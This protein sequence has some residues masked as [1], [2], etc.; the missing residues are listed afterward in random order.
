M[1]ELRARTERTP[2]AMGD[3]PGRLA[4]HS[5]WHSPLTM[6][7][8][9]SQWLSDDRLLAIMIAVDNDNMYANQWP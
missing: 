8:R 4:L 1:T 6:Q 9:D 2:L 3:K 7:V 5:S